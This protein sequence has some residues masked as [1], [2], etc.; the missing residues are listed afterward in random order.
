MSGLHVGDVSPVYAEHA[1]PTATPTWRT[2][3][4]AWRGRHRRENQVLRGRWDLPLGAHD[5]NDVIRSERVARVA[6]C[7]V[8]GCAWTS[9]ESAGVATWMHGGTFL[10]SPASP[11]QVKESN[12]G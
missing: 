1:G 5:E 3:T 9:G 6:G 2:T 4:C 8:T 7:V 12:V 11:S 10:M